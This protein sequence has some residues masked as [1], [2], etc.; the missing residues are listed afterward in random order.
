MSAKLIDS[1]KFVRDMQRE[2]SKGD[3][4]EGVVN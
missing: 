4:L 3:N 2:I 1:I